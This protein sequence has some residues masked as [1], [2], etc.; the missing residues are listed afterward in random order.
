[1]KRI[2]VLSLSFVFALSLQAQTKN[3]E[4]K[5]IPQPTTQAQPLQPMVNLRIPVPNFNTLVYLIRYTQMVDAKTAN[6]M[7]DF[8]V[9]QANDSTLNSQLRQTKPK[10]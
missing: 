7:A 1:M 6:E 3:K 4:K 2:T 5:E 9:N 8:L 10:Q